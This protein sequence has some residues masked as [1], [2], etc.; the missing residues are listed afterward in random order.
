MAHLPVL[1]YMAN[2]S[3]G[4]IL[5]L[6]YDTDSTMLLRDIAYTRNIPL[7]SI[8]DV[9]KYK[10]LAS[11]THTVYMNV[12]QCEHILRWGVVFINHPSWSERVK[13]MHQF[14]NITTYLV[15]TDADYF[16]GNKLFGSVQRITTHNSPGIYTFDDMFVSWKMYFPPTPWL[17]ASGPPTLVASTE[18]IGIP[19][20]IPCQFYRAIDNNQ[21]LV[22]EQCEYSGWGDNVLNILSGI[23]LANRL[24]RIPLLAFRLPLYAAFDMSIEAIRGNHT[25]CC[26][27]D[28]ANH[29]HSFDSLREVYTK[30]LVETFSTRHKCIHY[31]TYYPVM[32]F[33]MRQE[34]M[35]SN[36]KSLF[37]KYCKYTH[38]ALEKSVVVHIRI[39]DGALK[40]DH[41][42]TKSCPCVRSDQ[43]EKMLDSLSSAIPSGTEVCLI[44]DLSTLIHTVRSKLPQ[45]TW[46]QISTNIPLHSDAFTHSNDEN[47]S[48]MLHDFY[49]IYYANVSVVCQ[50]SNFGKLASYL[51]T[52]KSVFLWDASFT[53]RQV[54]DMNSLLVK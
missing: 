24:K 1:K 12:E 9:D 47:F 13:L 35:R 26:R 46:T 32:M 52:P 48:S 28:H 36:L 10:H 20:E 31:K 29:E 42:H 8:V 23:V 14:K 7:V 38:D 4:P 43:L 6:G 27:I 25:M 41:I 22:I 5:D 50:W 40:P 44:S 45:Y 51:G 53:C 19:D 37:T 11:P 30:P 15:I 49:T 3:K 17:S 16:P 34:E 39:G 21:Y 54:E 2:I 33:I 18:N